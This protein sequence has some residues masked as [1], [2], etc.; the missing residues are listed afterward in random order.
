MKK[1][2]KIIILLSI[3]FASCSTIKIEE[4]IV[5]DFVKEKNLKNIPYLGASYLIEE[6]FPSNEV[7]DH[8]EIASL[9]KKLPDGNQRMEII[10]SISDSNISMD[11]IKR[12][13][14]VSYISLNEIKQLKILHKNNNLVHHWNAKKFKTLE[15]PIMTKD[16]LL[17]KANKGIL[18]ASVTGHVISMP[19]VSLNKKYALLKYFYVS[20]PGGSSERTYLLEKGNGKWTV[21]QEI[22]NPNIYY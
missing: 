12:L 2:K 19:I 8:Y 21:K 4:Q 17:S 11:E 15:I 22:Y 5:Q 1:M 20:L 10:A 9:D 14:A 7:L 16:E 13:K 6:A 3:C 18:S